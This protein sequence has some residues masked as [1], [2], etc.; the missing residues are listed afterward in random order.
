VVV[1]DARNEAG[2]P[3]VSTDESRCTV[4]VLRTD[5]ESI[6][7]RETLAVLEGSRPGEDRAGPPEAVG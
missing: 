4:R 6:L 1:D 2:A 5:E 3:V 7:A